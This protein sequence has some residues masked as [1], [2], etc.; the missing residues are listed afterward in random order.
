MQ[1]HVSQP[2]VLTRRS[3]FTLIELLIVIALIATLTAL[4]VTVM[5]GI[6]DQANEA[7][8]V[9]TIRKIDALLEKRLRA[10][11]R[12]F[13]R[14]GKFRE[15]YILAARSLLNQDNIW[16]PLQGN[17]L[18]DDD[19]DPVVQFLAKK[20]AMRHNFPQ[21]HEDLL[22]LGFT[23][24]GKTPVTDFDKT[25]NIVGIA[26]RVID[27]N[28][29]RIPDVVEAS[30]ANQA[31]LL[32][33]HPAG[34]DNGGNYVNDSTVGAELLYFFIVHS[35]S[36]GTSDVAGDEFSTQEVADTDGDGLLEFV[37]AW[38]NPLRF[39]RWPTRMID[40]DAPSPFQPILASQSDPTD[41]DPT[42]LDDDGNPATIEDTD[43]LREIMPNERLVANLLI[44]GL[45]PAPTGLPNGAIPRDLLFTDPDDPVGVLYRGLEEYGGQA[46]Y[47][48]PAFAAE[49]NET[50]YHTP[51]TYH[52]PLIVSAGS[53][54]LLGLY[55]PCDTPNLGNLAAYDST[56]TF[57]TLLEQLSDN[58]TNRNRRAGGRR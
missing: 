18:T 32:A 29:N 6:T 17:P 8:T 51:D 54:G 9:A 15:R 19:D 21:R 45:P 31:A 10:F 35:A 2:V 28:G 23:A 40:V 46:N 52:V 7:A 14:P 33:L 58:L 37:D 41:L 55:E 57:D 34:G 53:D 38:G 13:N 24:N 22:L 36:L 43:S 50:N 42:P 5:Y 30:A 11:E 1:K 16:G 12:A 27:G 44:K 49:F 4:S 20:V 56:L 3:A 25:N 47:T 48:G 39:Y 26:S